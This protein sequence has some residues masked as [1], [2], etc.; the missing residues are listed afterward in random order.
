VAGPNP[1][2]LHCATVALDLALAA[3]DTDPDVRTVILVEHPG[4]GG[5]AT[6]LTGG[7][8]SAA[9]AERFAEAVLDG[10][11]DTGCRVV[12]ASLRPGTELVVA[13]DDLA[14]W[15]RLRARFAG[16]AAT[17]LD[18]FVVTDEEALSLAATAAPPT[19][20]HR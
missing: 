5:I 16:R 12:V 7:D 8:G 14:A 2:Q 3:A 17:L 13:E 18:W 6:T 19:P 9:E 1:L 15:R 10:V 4:G 20:W 11:G